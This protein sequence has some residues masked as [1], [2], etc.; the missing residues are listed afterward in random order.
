MVALASIILCNQKC[1]RPGEWVVMELSM[2]EKLVANAGWYIKCCIHKTAEWRG[3]LGKYIAPGTAK[4]LDLYLQ[5]PSRGAR[6]FEPVEVGARGVSMATLVG[7]WGQVYGV[8]HVAPT[9]FRKLYTDSVAIDQD[10][11]LARKLVAEVDT[12]SERVQTK[13][14]AVR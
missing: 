11:E 9:L 1:G 3:E 6:L 4:A 12:R 5:L 8:E 13:H 14:Y 2:V 10:S 7:R